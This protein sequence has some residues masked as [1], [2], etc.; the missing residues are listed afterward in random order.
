MDFLLCKEDMHQKAVDSLNQQHIRFQGFDTIDNRMSINYRSFK[1]LNP[2][3]ADQLAHIRFTRAMAEKL[4][5][6]RELFGR[7]NW[8][9]PK[10]CSIEKLQQMLESH[11]IRAKSDP[12]QYI[13]VAN[14]A[15]MIWFRKHFI[16]E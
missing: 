7:K 15:M 11:V 6:A 8:H 10:K 9:R 14:L 12:L 2:A 16:K 4:V 13:D 3:S 1:R 5:I